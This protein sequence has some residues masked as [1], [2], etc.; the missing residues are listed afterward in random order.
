MDH[1]VSEDR[2]NVFHV[3]VGD[4]WV[5][6][7]PDKEGVRSRKCVLGTGA[8]RGLN[9]AKKGFLQLSDKKLRDG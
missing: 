1:E 3:Q 5:E 8:R 6:K 2:R 9:C 7:L 4:G